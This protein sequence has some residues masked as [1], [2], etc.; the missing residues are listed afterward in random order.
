[1]RGTRSASPTGCPCG[2]RGTADEILP[3]SHFAL[4]TSGGP[5]APVADH[6]QHLFSPSIAALLATGAAGPPAIPVREVLALLDAAGMRRALVLS[7]AYLY[8]SPA[9]SVADEYA[10]VRAEN[11][12]T[13]AQAPQYPERLRA[14]GSVNPL[15]DYALAELARCARHPQLD[16]ASS[17]TSATRTCNWTSPPTSRS[18]GAC[19]G[20]PMSRVVRTPNAERGSRN[21]AAWVRVRQGP[22]ARVS[23]GVAAAGA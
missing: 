21:Q 11:D 22:G 9:R 20:P 19:F 13:G 23:G 4:P 15:K 5:G 12:W 1:M 8:G 6:H 10:R 17:C 2:E 7:V 14:F 18:S 16:P 3:R